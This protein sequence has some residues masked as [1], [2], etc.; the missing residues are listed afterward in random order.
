MDQSSSVLHLG[1]RLV[2]AGD[3]RPVSAGITG[4]PYLYQ[5]LTRLTGPGS[6]EP[7]DEQSAMLI[8]EIAERFRWE[9]PASGLLLA[10]WVTLAPICGALP[11]RP[12]IRRQPLRL[13]AAPIL[14]GDLSIQSRRQLDRSSILFI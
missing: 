5:R 13:S 7:L 1:D 11:W 3:L 2:V 8:W 6:A 4:S 12:H 14:G 10:G 9:V